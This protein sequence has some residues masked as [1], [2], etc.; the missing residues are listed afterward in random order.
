VSPRRQRLSD[1]FLVREAAEDDAEQLTAFA[2]STGRACEDEVERFVQGKALECAL[3][4]LHH[5][6]RLLLVHEEKRLVACAGYHREPLVLKSV[7]EPEIAVLIQLLAIGL[8]DQGRRLPDGVA[9]SDAVL[10]TAIFNAMET[11]EHDIFTAIVAQEN[12][13][14][15]AVCERNGL[16]SQIGYGPGYVRLSGRFQA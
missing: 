2:C 10:Q 9:L 6:Y 12:L 8:P 5:S 16:R 11:L 13:R 3:S 15:M 4:G 1:D 14:A 7:E